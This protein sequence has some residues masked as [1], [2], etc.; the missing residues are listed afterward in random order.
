MNLKFGI[1]RCFITG[2]TALSLD[3]TRGFK[4]AKDVSLHK[5]LAGLCG[6]TFPDVEAALA[7]ICDSEVETKKHLSELTKYTDGYHFCSDNRVA[8]VY[9]TVT[10]LEYLQVSNENIWTSGPL[11]V[12]LLV[13]RP[14]C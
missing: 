12:F 10:C 14:G 5:E 4:L 7:K 2:T 11:S 9:S 13:I 1:R 6:L 3:D 8:N